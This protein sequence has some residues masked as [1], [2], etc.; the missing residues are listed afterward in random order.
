MPPLSF[1]RFR[2]LVA[3]YGAR[4][5][6]WPEDEAAAAREL[7]AAS[8]EARG[9]LALEAELDRELVAASSPPEVPARLLRR[10]NEVP[11]RAPQRRAWWPFGRTWVP[12]LGFAFAAALG[13][14]LGM[15]TGSFETSDLGQE[16]AVVTA[17][18]AASP[19][20]VPA[21]EE[22]FSAIARGTL[23]EFEE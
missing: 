6:L 2:E 16:T 10:L 1:D 22:E 18:S 5:E 12:A 20:Q 4:L 15:F 14:G 3:A 11:I 8:A 23:V 21:G 13:V 7:V 19:A 17:D 9:L